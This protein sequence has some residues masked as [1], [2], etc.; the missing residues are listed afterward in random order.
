MKILCT[1]HTDYMEYGPHRFME[2]TY[3]VSAIPT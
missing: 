2:Y 1:D 3:G